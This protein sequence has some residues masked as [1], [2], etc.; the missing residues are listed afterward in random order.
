MLLS[1]LYLALFLAVPMGRSLAALFE[2]R[3]DEREA[4]GCSELWGDVE[5]FL[6]VVARGSLRL[7]IFRSNDGNLPLRLG[8]V[9]PIP[10]LLTAYLAQQRQRREK[11]VS[12]M[13]ETN[14]KS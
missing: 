5:I 8:D 11:K 1:A 10:V 12:I 3:K 2:I 14:G 13:E 7:C 6:R 9:I 4:I